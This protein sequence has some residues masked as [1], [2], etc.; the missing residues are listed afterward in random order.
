M[1][2]VGTG[3]PG[4]LQRFGFP[5]EVS[6]NAPDAEIVDLPRPELGVERG[7]IRNVFEHYPFEVGSG[8]VIAGVGIQQYP[9]P[10][11][12]SPQRNGPVP[13]GAL[14]KGAVFGSLTFPRICAGVMKVSA[15]STDRANRAFHAPVDLVGRHDGNVPDE[16]VPDAV[17]C[18]ETGRVDQVER[19]FDIR[20]VNAVPSCHF[21]SFL[22][23]IF[24]A[25]RPPKSRHWRRSGPRGRDPARNGRSGR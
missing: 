20:C 9:I 3:L 25:S 10:A 19:V 2:G 14:L 18:P 7:E 21:A 1:K 13:T 24:Q 23:L 4:R 5:R 17:A 11:T 6:G 22:S 16:A 12:R 15:R 8:A